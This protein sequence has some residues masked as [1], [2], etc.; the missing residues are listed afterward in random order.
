MR[1][2]RN[3]PVQSFYS[4]PWSFFN[5]KSNALWSFW[6]FHWFASRK[7]CQFQNVNVIRIPNCF[8]CW[9]HES[10]RAL[11]LNS[12]SRIAMI[13]PVWHESFK[14]LIINIPRQFHSISLPYWEYWN[15][16]RNTLAYSPILSEKLRFAFQLHPI[17]LTW[18]LK[19]FGICRW[20]IFKS[21][22]SACRHK[23]WNVKSKF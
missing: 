17:F 3:I 13:G 19:W 8:Q 21:I 16:E 9:A 20:C 14:Q 7:K 22:I 23:Y 11:L 1:K 6:F 2:N 18:K 5:W 4:N 12:L 15:K 10:H